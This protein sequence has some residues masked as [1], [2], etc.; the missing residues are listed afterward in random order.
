MLPSNWPSSFAESPYGFLDSCFVMSYP[1]MSHS[2]TL[3]TGKFI[4]PAVH[5]GVGVAKLLD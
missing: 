4:E 2:I 1:S 5:L 3:S